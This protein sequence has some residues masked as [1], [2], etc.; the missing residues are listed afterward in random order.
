[1]TLDAPDLLPA[2]AGPTRYRV[3]HRTAYWYGQAMA[4]GNTVA[5]LAP[6][7]TPW[8]TVASSVVV[9]DPLPDERDEWTD[10]FGNRVLQFAIHHA[11][12]AMTITST[13]EVD[14]RVMP[15]PDCALTWEQ[16]AAWTDPIVDQYRAPSPL[17]LPN[18]AGAELERLAAEAFLPRRNVVE[19]I[20][21]LTATIFH[22]FLFDPSFSDVSTP[23][24]EVVTARR[25]VCQDFAHLALACLR[26]VGLPARYVSG[27]LETEPPPGLAKLIGAD[28]SHAWCAVALPGIAGGWLDL[29]PTNDQVP[30]RHHVTVAWGRDYADVAPVRGVVLGPPS[31]QQL[32]VA[33]DVQRLDPWG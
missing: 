4:R 8:Q 5:H 19:A 16:V 12:D 14:V 22:E 11:H 13:S 17:A 33:V 9:I 31:D 23:L 26:S 25:G 10:V 30:P 7:D 18:G 32:E 20:D 24:A 29:D 1:M 6:R 2:P 3:T 27:Y 15:R 21:A 28:A